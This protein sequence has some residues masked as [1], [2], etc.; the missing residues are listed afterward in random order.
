MYVFPAGSFTASPQA[1]LPHSIAGDAIAHTVEL[2]E[3]FDVDVDQLAAMFALIAP[4]RSVG[5]KSRNQFNP[6]RRGIRPTVADATP[7]STAIC[8]P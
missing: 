7:T 4:R 5:S 3:L 8:L 1:A 2:V 6:S